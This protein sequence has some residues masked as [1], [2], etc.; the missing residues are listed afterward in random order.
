VSSDYL[1]ITIEE[2]NLSVRCDIC[3]KRGAINTVGDVV[4]RTEA[5]LMDLRNFGQQ[6][7]D[8]IKGKLSELGLFLA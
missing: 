1:R 7:L 3:L 6:C 5:E 4:Q 2:L 8:E